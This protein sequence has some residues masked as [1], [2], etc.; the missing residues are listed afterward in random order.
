[1]SAVGGLN[2]IW[3]QGLKGEGGENRNLNTASGRED[4]T[5]KTLNTEEEKKACDSTCL[6][7]KKNQKGVIT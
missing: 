2:N 1:M 7:S 3:P 4:V 6:T 5:N